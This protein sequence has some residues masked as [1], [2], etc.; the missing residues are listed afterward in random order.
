M[1][2]YKYNIITNFFISEVEIDPKTVLPKGVTL[3]AKGDNENF[4]TGSTWVYKEPNFEKPLKFNTYYNSDESLTSEG[5]P[6]LGLND[7]YYAPLS[8]D[9]SV[10]AK[11]VDSQGTIQTQIDQTEL[12]FPSVLKLPVNKYL[13]GID[14]QVIDEV[15]FNATLTEGVLTATGKI[16]SS[17]DWKLTTERLNKSIEAIGGSFKIDRQ[18]IT[19][20]V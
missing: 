20:L 17:G 4:F 18:N 15:Y 14:G 10:S 6:L 1:K 5:N 11:I 9:I 8:T 7:T 16:P 19:F 2:A 12:G 13:G 3:I